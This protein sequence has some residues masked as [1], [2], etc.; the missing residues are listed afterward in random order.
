LRRF[1]GDEDWVAHCP[2][3]M[4][5]D[6]SWAWEGGNFGCFSVSRH[7]LIDGSTVLIG[8]HS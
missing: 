7:E 1:G 8:A 4:D 5:A 6:P 2:A 3:G